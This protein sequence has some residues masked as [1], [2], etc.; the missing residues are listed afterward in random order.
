MTRSGQML[1]IWRLGSRTQQGKAA[2]EVANRGCGASQGNVKNKQRKTNKCD[3]IWLSK[4]IIAVGKMDHL[5]K[6]PVSVIR[7]CRREFGGTTIYAVNSGDGFCG[8]IMD[9]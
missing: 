5:R 6:S 7:P 2:L 4:G 9:A 3:G 8:Q 1:C